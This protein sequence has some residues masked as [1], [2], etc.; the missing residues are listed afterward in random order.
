ML[1]SSGRCSASHFFHAVLNN[2]NATSSTPECQNDAV[3]EANC[4]GR[5]WMV[6]GAPAILQRSMMQPVL[7]QSVS[8]RHGCDTLPATFLNFLYPLIVGIQAYHVVD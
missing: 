1:V 3:N 7:E 6:F 2:A 5:A 8:T 4:V